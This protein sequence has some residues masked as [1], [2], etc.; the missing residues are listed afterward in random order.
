MEPHLSGRSECIRNQQITFLRD[1]SDISRVLREMGQ[2]LTDL[3]GERHLSMNQA[4][5]V[6]GCPY[7]LIRRIEIGEN[8]EL[9]GLFT[10]TDA[11]DIS[12]ELHY[13]L[14][15]DKKEQ[16]CEKHLFHEKLMVLN[17][18]I[19]QLVKT[20]GLKRRIDGF[21]TIDNDCVQNELSGWENKTHLHLKQM[22]KLLGDAGVYL[23]MVIPNIY[24][25]LYG[26]VSSDLPT[27]MVKE[28]GTKKLESHIILL[29]ESISV[30]DAL[31]KIGQIIEQTRRN[32]EK[33]LQQMANS[34]EMSFGT[35][36]RCE[37]GRN[38]ALA[39]V[40]AIAAA[41]S[42]QFELSYMREV[43]PDV[44]KWKK[45]DLAKPD[46]PHAFVLGCIIN[47]AR[48]ALGLTQSGAASQFQLNRNE[49]SRIEN[50][51][52][53]I[54]TK[55]FLKLLRAFNIELNIVVPKPQKVRPFQKIR[56]PAT[57]FKSNRS[58]KVVHL[59]V[60]VNPLSNL[61]KTIGSVFHQVRAGANQT[62]RVAGDAA[63]VDNS[64]FSKIEKGRIDMR[65]STFIGICR[66]IGVTVEVVYPVGTKRRKASHEMAVEF[67]RHDIVRS[68]LSPMK[69][70]GRIMRTVRKDG[71]KSL[72]DLGAEIGIDDSKL[73][74]MENDR[75]DP[76]MKT[77]GRILLSL[78][79]IMEL[80]FPWTEEPKRKVVASLDQANK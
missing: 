32:D 62:V 57:R 43:R 9:Q 67:K 26:P 47:D 75:M 2:I 12:F 65:V 33:T 60:G 45:E 10:V 38:M 20:I 80:N 28:I 17:V 8:V 76:Q 18:S 61:L 5:K 71:Q 68:R 13:P 21:G 44:F 34:C 53:E 6:I 39:G 40:L 73:A 15:E 72:R 30:N 49:L 11:Y 78:G 64:K 35:L 3:R 41:N 48:R 52:T 1:H 56:L 7:S 63:D 42:I 23:Q 31:K 54:T 79:I 19:N 70:I 37:K 24:P 69:A 36:Q 14:K 4:A 74:K 51:Q 59:L 16:R 77:L 66:S 25:M 58:N 22:L 46:A 27:K 50:G 29:D 55:T